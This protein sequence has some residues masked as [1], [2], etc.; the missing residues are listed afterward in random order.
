[1]KLRISR[2]LAAALL[3]SFATAH[4]GEPITFGADLGNVMYVGDSITDG[5]SETLDYGV[6]LGK[7]LNKA[8]QQIPQMNAQH[9]KELDDALKDM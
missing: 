6:T 5:V 3:A 9:N 4:A 1:M 8:K 2:F 7:T